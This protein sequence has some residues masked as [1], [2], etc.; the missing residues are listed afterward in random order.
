MP[1]ILVPFTQSVQTDICFWKWIQDIK[2]SVVHGWSG[3][4]QWGRMFGVL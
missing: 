1:P 3:G 2:Q 4:H